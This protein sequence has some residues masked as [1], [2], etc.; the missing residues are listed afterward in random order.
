MRGG[1]FD[2]MIHAALSFWSMAFDPDQAFLL[3]RAREILDVMLKK[4]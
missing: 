1:F 2:G 3:H 4:S